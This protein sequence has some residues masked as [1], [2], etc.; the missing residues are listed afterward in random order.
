MD[1]LTVHVAKC[2]MELKD[3]NIC[4]SFVHT[5]WRDKPTMLVFNN[6]N[7]KIVTSWFDP[8]LQEGDIEVLEKL[9]I[10]FLIDVDK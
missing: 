3:V 6:L 10:N 4:L 8:I 2:T 7:S 1:N 9:V 5:I